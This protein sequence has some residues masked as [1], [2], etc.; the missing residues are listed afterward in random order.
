MNPKS[1]CR[2]QN[3]SLSCQHYL[4]AKHF[5]TQRGHLSTC[6]A[7]GCAVKWQLKHL[8]ISQWEGKKRETIMRNHLLH[9][10][11]CSSRCFSRTVFLKVL[12]RPWTLSEM[13]ILRSDLRPFHTETQGGWGRRILKSI[14]K[15]FWMILMRARVWKLLFLRR[16]DWNRKEVF[17]Q[18]I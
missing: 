2:C 12:S 14:W 16:L 11:H 9:S 6:Q 10:F 7:M 4:F 17:V 15:A 18:K 3:C 8:F 1:R 13:Q 5:S